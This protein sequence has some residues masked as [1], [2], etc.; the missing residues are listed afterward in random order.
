MNNIT[1]LFLAEYDIHSTQGISLIFII[2]LIII[3][4]IITLI[5]IYIYI[6]IDILAFIYMLLCQKHYSQ[7]GYIYV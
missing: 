3:I 2:T 7:D 1:H 4:I 6:Y 5:Y